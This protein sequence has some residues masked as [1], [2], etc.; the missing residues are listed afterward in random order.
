MFLPGVESGAQPGPY[1]DAIET[2]RKAGHEYPQIRQLLAY[3][4]GIDDQD[5]VV[6]YETDDLLAFGSL[7]RDLRATESRRST[8]RDTPILT[9]IHRPVQEILHLLGA[10]L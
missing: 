6:A 4:F 10:P 9:G 5:F 7:V 2:K 1:L 8:V 3:S